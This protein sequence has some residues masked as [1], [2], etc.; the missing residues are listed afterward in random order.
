MTISGLSGPSELRGWK[1][2][3]RILRLGDLGRQAHY[4]WIFWLSLTN[5]ESEANPNNNLMM[6]LVYLYLGGHLKRW[7]WNGVMEAGGGMY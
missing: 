3:L 5:S 2:D 1:G 7:G 6:T 4:L